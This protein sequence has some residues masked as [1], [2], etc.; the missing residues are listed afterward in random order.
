MT[1]IEGGES[2]GVGIEAQEDMNIIRMQIAIF[3][4]FPCKSILLRGF[5]RIPCLP[6]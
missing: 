2:G 1:K 6:H 3:I 4:V 5:G